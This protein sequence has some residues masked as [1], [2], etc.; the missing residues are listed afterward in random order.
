MRGLLKNAHGARIRQKFIRQALS[1]RA[2]NDQR[3]LGEEYI[4]LGLNKL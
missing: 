4:R 1:V 3:D 2:A